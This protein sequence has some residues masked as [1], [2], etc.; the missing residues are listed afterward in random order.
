MTSMKIEFSAKEKTGKG[1][2]RKLRMKQLIPAV[3]YGPDF[4]QGTAGAVSGKLISPVAN[5]PHRETTVIELVMPDGSVKSAL[6]K[7]I[8]KH[9]TSRRL[10]H[11]DFVQVIKGQKM[12]V[13]IP[14]IT[15]NKDISRGIKDGGML[16]QQIRTITIEV[17]PKDIPGDICVDLKDMQLGAEIFA[18][19][20]P[21]PESAE[22]ITDPCQL[23]LQITQTRSAAAEASAEGEAEEVEVVAKG[24][25]KE[26]E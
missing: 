20:L 13:E 9:P 5:G 8:Q 2:N 4:K 10:L 16:D 24:K 26:G 11:L 3:L 22:L 6:I 14:V 21:L 25:A 1:V 15:A 17:L 19:D 7:D 18:R 23:V 12:K